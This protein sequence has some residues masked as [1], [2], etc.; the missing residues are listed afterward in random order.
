MFNKSL[1][2]CCNEGKD[3][4]RYNESEFSYKFF[5]SV[6]LLNIYENLLKLI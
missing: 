1:P 4:P 5:T 6:S 2:D 3:Y